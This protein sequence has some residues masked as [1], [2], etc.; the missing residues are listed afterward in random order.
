MEQDG[1]WGTFVFTHWRSEMEMIV[2]ASGSETLLQLRIGQKLSC[3]SDKIVVS[4]FVEN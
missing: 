3:Q 1:M 2:G 4:Q